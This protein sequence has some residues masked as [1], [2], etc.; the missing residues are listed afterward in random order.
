MRSA[1]L[2]RAQVVVSSRDTRWDAH[3]KRVVRFGRFRL[4]FC[5]MIHNRITMGLGLYHPL[6]GSTRC[7]LFGWGA[8]KLASLLQYSARPGTG[9]VTRSP[10]AAGTMLASLCAT[11]HAVRLTL[12][13][14][15]N[16]AESRL[17]ATSGAIAGCTV[18]SL[19]PQEVASHTEVH[20]AVTV[21]ALQAALPRGWSIGAQPSARS[22]E[23]LPPGYDGGG[24]VVR[25]GL[26]AAV[27]SASL[28]SLL[29]VREG[30]RAHIGHFLPWV[31]CSTDKFPSLWLAL[32]LLRARTLR[33]L[34]W[35][36]P[37]Q[38]LTTGSTVTLRSDALMTTVR[39]AV[40][41]SCLQT[42]VSILAHCGRH[43]R[44]EAGWL[45]GLFILVLPASARP[46]LAC[47]LAHHSLF[48][49]LR[50]AVGADASWATALVA[51]GCDKV[52]LAA[53]LAVIMNEYTVV[54]PSTRDSVMSRHTRQLLHHLLGY[55]HAEPPRKPAAA[56][57]AAADIVVCML[58]SITFEP[59]SGDHAKVSTIRLPQHVAV[60][61]ALA[62]RS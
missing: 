56:A 14:F 52:S 38:L 33:Q 6:A 15:S 12:Q 61:I 39:T 57:P 53:G 1:E 18:A 60:Q 37:A 22:G 29:L 4:L 48:A 20:T 27:A 9:F 8:A 45:P 25:A 54:G 26:P 21:G 32:S 42:S 51:Q 46:S 40:G 28:W 31:I 11:Y 43:V 24:W 17:A 16:L 23:Q 3:G 44:L 50:L 35:A 47:R 19:W 58:G 10:I 2:P 34:R 55:D 36:L 41:L 62:A 59:P 5:V 49:L 13:W 7:F 30:D